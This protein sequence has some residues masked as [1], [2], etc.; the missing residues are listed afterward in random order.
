MSIG[1]IAAVAGT[2]LG[3]LFLWRTRG[4]AKKVVGTPADMATHPVFAA[5][6]A[7]A[8]ANPMAAAAAQPPSTWR[9]VSDADDSWFENV[10]TGETAWDLPP[11]AAL[12]TGDQQPPGQPASGE[13]PP[14]W[15]HYSD[16]ADS[17]YVDQAG[18]AHWTLP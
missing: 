16:G 10:A 17:W 5:S 9:A 2:G 3:A 1:T 8:V 18:E 13:L 11:G 7:V 14:G 12:E 6:A 4:G 15:R